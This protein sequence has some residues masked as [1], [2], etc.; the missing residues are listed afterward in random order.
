VKEVCPRPTPGLRKQAIK[1]AGKRRA[2]RRPQEEK[3][4]DHIGLKDQKK[5]ELHPGEERVQDM[6]VT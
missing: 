1:S 4:N 5:K 3:G 6:E 2:L